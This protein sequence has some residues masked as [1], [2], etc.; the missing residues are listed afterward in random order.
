MKIINILIVSLIFVSSA[1][2]QDVSFA[3]DYEKPD[4]VSPSALSFH[5]YAK[6]YQEGEPLESGNWRKVGTVTGTNRTAKI[7]LPNRSIVRVTAQVN[8][9]ES[10]P[11]NAV[12][13]NNAPPPGSTPPAPS[14]LRFQIDI[15]INVNVNQ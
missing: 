12:D 6:D 8:D 5:V 1:I 9:V 15:N 13:T 3:W 2:A 14:N 10:G 4:N 7:D 11:S